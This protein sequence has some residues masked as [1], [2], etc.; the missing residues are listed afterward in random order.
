MNLAQWK[1]LGFE[2]EGHG[3]SGDTLTRSFPNKHYIMIDGIGDH[4]MEIPQEGT[5]IQKT[6]PDFLP[7]RDDVT[8][9]TGHRPPT[10]SEIRFGHAVTHYR[11]F[12]VAIWKHP[13]GK[14]KKWIKAPD[15]GLRYYR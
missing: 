15:D 6:M 13:N 12:P 9:I 11:T 5:E 14:P 8:E 10:K 7:F 4:E 1:E 3:P 2:P